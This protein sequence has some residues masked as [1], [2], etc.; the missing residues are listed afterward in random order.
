MLTELNPAQ[1]DAVLAT[2]GPVLILAGAGSGK[3]RVI[4]HRIAYLV[5]EKGVDPA[6]ILAVTFTNKAAGEMRARVERLLGQQINFFWLGTFHAV[7]V[8]I[9]RREAAHLHLPTNFTILDDDDSQSMIAREMKELGIDT[10]QYRAADFQAVISRAKNDMTNVSTFSANAVG[11]FQRTA[12]LL[13]S[14]YEKAKERADSLDFDDLLLKV[15]ELFERHPAVLAKYRD[16]F[17]YLMID[18]YQDINRVQYIW[19][20]LLAAGSRNVCVVGDDAQA[21][22]G[23]RGADFRT[24][25]DFERDY[26]DAKVVLLE[27]NYRSTQTI[28]EA[29]NAVIAKNIMQKRKKLWTE[30]NGGAPVTVFEANDEIDEGEFILSEIRSHQM[31]GFHQER[32]VN[33][34][35]GIASS[36]ANRQARKD[37]LN[38]FA[39]LFR[40]FAQSRALE[41]AF[42]RARLP[43]KIVGGVRFYERREVKDILAYLRFLENPRDWVSLE[44]IINVPRRGIGDKMLAE[45]RGAFLANRLDNVLHPPAQKFFDSMRTLRKKKET[46]PPDELIEHVMVDTGYGLHLEDG[47]LSGDTRAENIHELKTVAQQFTTLA[48]LLADI[49]LTTDID[50]YDEQDNS[51]TLMTLHAA[52]GLE[53]PV[54]FIVG[55]EEGLFPHAKSIT[56]TAQLEEER[57]LCYVG[58]TRAKERLYLLRARTRTLYGVIQENPPSRFLADLPDHLIE[59]I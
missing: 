43:Y 20:K 36:T 10:R 24:I 41:D 3:T 35:Y 6:N 28:L 23:W 54:V 53:F 19:T 15:V 11:P 45:I 48:D 26:P 47:I 21:I 4:A 38:N 46:L 58:M 37:G 1:Q 17:H 50:R 16:Q 7:S 49:A 59:V 9:L 57:R 13:F 52:K 14:H 32:L 12:A 30:K 25:L 5:K 44:R 27:Q 55:M 42:V 33:A 40:T 22:Y 39:V 8:K 2:N 31:A 56:D 34:P 29:A 51:V 18:E